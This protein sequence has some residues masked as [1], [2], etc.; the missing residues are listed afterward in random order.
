M[1]SRNKMPLVSI[2]IPIYKVEKY[3]RRCVDSVI[4]QTYKKIEIILVDDG[5]PDKCGR[6]C[7]EYK[8]TDERIMVIHKENGGLSDA[9]NVALEICNGTYITF[10]D[11]DDWVS[12]FYVEHLVEA[13]RYSDADLVISMFENVFEDKHVLKASSIQVE[14]LEIVGTEDCYKRILYQ[15]GIEFNAPGKLYKRDMFTDLQYPVGKLYE[16]IPVTTEVIHRSSKIAVIQNIDYY[17][18]CRSKSI[19]HQDYTHKKMDAVAHILQM[20]TF[21]DDKYPVLF[22]ATTCRVF[23]TTCN[24][25]L[26][27]K[28]RREYQNDFDYLWTIIKMSRGVVLT[29]KNARKKARIAALISYLGFPM[30]KM[31]YSFNRLSK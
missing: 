17:Y 29:D 3:I 13:V 8:E 21:I 11:S 25:L 2:I 28:N 23:C 31:F 7:D 6:I 14:D 19:Q 30:L 15:E 10:I 12:E 1:E 20:K 9:R 4:S 16:D 27:I 24:I 5:S 22:K 18:F 26:Q